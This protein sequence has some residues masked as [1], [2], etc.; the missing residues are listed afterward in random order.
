MQ[1]CMESC[2]NFRAVDSSLATSLEA[3]AHHQNL[4]TLSLFYRYYFG[5][6]SSE[7]LL[8]SHS[9]GRSTLYSNRLHDF[10]V[11]IQC[12]RLRIFCLQNAFL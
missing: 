10:S 3:L 11:T 7:L 12:Q 6:C 2:C 8:L 5:R 1:H 9:Y 4:A